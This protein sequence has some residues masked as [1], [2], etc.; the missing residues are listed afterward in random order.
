MG[1]IFV[2]FRMQP[3]RDYSERTAFLLALIRQEGTIGG[4]EW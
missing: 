4:G 3:Y 2:L 1:V